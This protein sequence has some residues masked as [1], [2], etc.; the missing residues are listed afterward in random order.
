MFKRI[1]TSP[2]LYCILVVLLLGT[3]VVAKGNEKELP[4]SAAAIRKTVVDTDWD[5]EADEVRTDTMKGTNG[6]IRSV[7]PPT[8]E[9]KQFFRTH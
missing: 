5:S 2:P 6:F 3:A 9:E 7:R 4:S 8:E 1:L